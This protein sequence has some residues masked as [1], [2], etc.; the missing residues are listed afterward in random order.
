MS[1]TTHESLSEI[2]HVFKSISLP[3][4]RKL[5]DQGQSVE[6]LHPTVEMLAAITARYDRGELVDTSDK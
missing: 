2:V 1:F 5:L 4:L 3:G 6:I